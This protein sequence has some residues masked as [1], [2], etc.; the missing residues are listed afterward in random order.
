[1][2]IL[3]AALASVLALSSAGA[4][5]AASNGMAMVLGPG[6]QS[7]GT[8]LDDRREDLAP[9]RSDMAWVLGYIS[10][11]N[12]RGPGDGNVSAGTDAAGMAAELDKICREHPLES[13]TEAT[14]DLITQM[15]VDR[16]LRGVSPSH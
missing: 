13:I 4:S 9:E 15:T 3:I 7:C 12:R 16:V 2:R 11:V 14:D 1:M 5:R 10:A 6:A 8:W